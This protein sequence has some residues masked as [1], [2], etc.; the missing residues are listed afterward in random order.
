MAALVDEMA[1]TLLLLLLFVSDDSLISRLAMGIV[2][3][4]ALALGPT[5]LLLFSPVCLWFLSF[6]FLLPMV[7]LLK[8]SCFLL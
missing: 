3:M 5:L 2:L 8:L 7:T 1:L 4:F 6:S